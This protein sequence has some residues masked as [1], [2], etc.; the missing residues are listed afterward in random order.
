MLLSTTW[1]LKVPTFKTIEMEIVLSIPD[2][3]VL[4]DRLSTLLAAPIL[5]TPKL[6]LDQLWSF[7]QS[8]M[9]L[10]TF[11]ANDLLVLGQI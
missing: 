10:Q 1:R 3:T 4:S 11:T 6:A 9:V 2:T 8:L 5:S 7:R